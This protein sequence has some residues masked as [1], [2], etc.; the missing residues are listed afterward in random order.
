MASI[1]QTYKQKADPETGKRVFILNA[2]GEKIP[3]PR[4]RGKL[5]LANGKVRKV[6]L[7]RHKAESERLLFQMQDEQD[8]I[9]KGL[10]PLP[11]KFNKAM[12]RPFAEV[13]SEYIAWGAAQGGRG[14]RPWAPKVKGSH[15]AHLEWWGKELSLVE[16][17][18]MDGTLPQA[19]K[20]LRD[21]KE[22][23]K[24][25]KTLNHYRNDLFAFCEWCRK[26]DY[27]KENPFTGLER[28]A[29]VPVKERIRR[30]WTF[31]ELR[32]IIDDT[33]EHRSILYE[34]AVLTGYRANELRSL[35]VS[36]LDAENHIVRLDAEYDKGRKDRE[37]FISPELTARLQAFIASGEAIELYGRYN[38]TRKESIVIPF[39][40]LLFVPYHTDR[41]VYDDLERLGIPKRTELGK[42][43]FHSLRV[44]FD[45]LL[46]KAGADVK[47]AQEMMRHS[48]PQLTLNVYGRGDAKR[49]REMASKVRGLVFDG[50]ARPISGQQEKP[51]IS[52]ENASPYFIGRCAQEILVAGAGFECAAGFS[53]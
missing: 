4:Y 35:S 21:M 13:A 12:R 9:R 20:A 17:G 38:H 33:P 51:S 23:G 1:F 7:T 14:G 48:T 8:K 40:P 11:D 50:E 45:N 46:L 2:K 44:A 22:T 18:D 34:T 6:T 24:S 49:K 41:M 31:A 53:W 42:L 28:F 25:G 15:R 36:H 52:K 30:D 26:R 32:R 10:I 37:Q 3:H 43:D 5:Q 27:L 16:M 19:E 47:T 29:S 39:R